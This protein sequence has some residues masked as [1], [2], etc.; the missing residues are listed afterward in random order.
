MLDEI[1]LDRERSRVARERARREAAR[2]DLER[3]APRMVEGRRMRQRDLAD[4][5]HPHVQRGVG[6]LPRV[7]GELRPRVAHGA[8]GNDTLA[9]WLIPARISRRWTTSS[10]R[11]SASAKSASASVPAGCTFVPARAAAR[12]SAATRRPIA[13]PAST[14]ELRRIRSSRRRNRANAGCTASPTIR[15]LNTKQVS[16]LKAQLSIFLSLE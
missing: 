16:S 13:T 10:I 15:L 2:R 7:V 5:L 11:R 6:V 14:P 12:R 8:S 4:D 1:E 9:I 3:N